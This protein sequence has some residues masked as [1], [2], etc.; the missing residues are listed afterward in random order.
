MNFIFIF[1]VKRWII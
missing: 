1:F